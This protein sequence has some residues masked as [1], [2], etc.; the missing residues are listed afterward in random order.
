MHGTRG[1]AGWRGVL[2]VPCFGRRSC[3]AL[4]DAPD[5]SSLADAVAVAVATVAT[6]GMS[7]RCGGSATTS[8]VAMSC[9]H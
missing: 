3:N 5:A 7:W 6:A 4:G 8:S 9:A 1:V 2:S